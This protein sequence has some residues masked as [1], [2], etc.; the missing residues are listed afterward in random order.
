MKLEAFDA[1]AKPKIIREVKAMVPNLTLI[2]VCVMLLSFVRFWT[3][4]HGA[5]SARLPF[6]GEEIRRVPTAGP[7][8]GPLEGGRG[9]A[10]KD[11]HGPRRHC[12]AGV[13]DIRLVC[14]ILCARRVRVLDTIGIGP[15]S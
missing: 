13:D 15:M 1:A 12:C 4:R 8:G 14:V 11:V 2:E 10:Q 7:Q 3:K 9:E 6:P 5:T